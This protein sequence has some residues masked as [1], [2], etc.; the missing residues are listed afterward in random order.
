MGALPAHGT[1]LYPKNFGYGEIWNR[2]GASLG[3]SLVTNCSVEKIDLEKRLVNDV[4]AAEKI[5]STI[6]WPLW[7]KYCSIPKPVL[8]AIRRLKNASI[9]I[10]YYP[11][12]I[13][14]KAHWIYEPDESISYHRL[15]L[16]EN[17]LE[18]SRGH[19]TETNSARL[20]TKQ[21]NFKFHNDFAYPINT[22]TKPRDVEMILKWA[23]LYGVIGL[24]RWGKWEHMNSDVAVAEALELV[25][26]LTSD[27]NK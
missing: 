23:E 3:D 20:T 17:F 13:K 12:S 8:D 22:F 4:W 15:L 25:G 7:E 24:G 14:S 9:D 26:R 16:R 18:G 5:V 2:M 1:F 11:E 6:P 27:A 19:W 10:N 21:S